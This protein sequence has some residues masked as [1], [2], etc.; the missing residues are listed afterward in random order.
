MTALKNV[1]AI[2]EKE[3]RHYFGS[4]IAYVVLF[5][6][7][8]LFGRF[9]YMGVSAFVEYA[10][11]TMSGGP[12]LNDQLIGPLFNNMSITAMFLAPMLTM[13]LFAEEKR[14]GTIEF[15]ATAPLTDAQ[16]VLGK[17]L[18]AAG[19]WA[20]MLLAGAVNFA[21]LWSHATPAPEWKP[22]AA[23]LLGLFLFGATFISL[24][25]FLSTLTK[26]QMVAGLL[27]FC[28]FLAMFTLAWA[29]TPNAGWVGKS[30]AYLAP[31]AHMMEMLKGVIEL[32]DLVYFASVI[33]FGVF[34]AHQSVASERWRA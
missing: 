9:F 1:A 10:M 5:V 8:Y 12:S 33:F 18:A 19:L 28:L 25:T 15:L 31:N 7:T 11:R 29:D 30:L 21:V 34:L 16:I 22:V 20:F 3:W 4:P 27:S 23:G 13:R 17:F 32:K 6:W 24:G 26:N 14:Q 2:I